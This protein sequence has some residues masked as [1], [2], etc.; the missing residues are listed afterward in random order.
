MSS[1][2]K[3][4]DATDPA[5]FA[6][7]TEGPLTAEMYRDRYGEKWHVVAPDGDTA[8][9]VLTRGPGTT[10]EER[11]ANARL[12]AA[13]PALLREVRSL[14]ARVA[15]LEAERDAAIELLRS[16]SRHYSLYSREEGTAKVREAVRVAISR[17]P[18]AT[19]PAGEE[20]ERG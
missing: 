7:H 13:S 16:N 9:A 15:G 18:A 10:P 3:P 14:R 20:A 2:P 5:A 12:W 17:S 11:A 4:P 1:T 8:L 6:G 19:P